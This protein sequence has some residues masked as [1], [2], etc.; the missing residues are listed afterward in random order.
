MAERI[1]I[2]EVTLDN[3]S[4]PVEEREIEVKPDSDDTTAKFLY[5]VQREMENGLYFYT[6]KGKWRHGIPR[7]RRE[8][9]DIKVQYPNPDEMREVLKSL[10]GEGKHVV[11]YKKDDEILGFNLVEAKKK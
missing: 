4:T 11:V 1:R 5:G 3:G 8:L 2:K 10:K 6:R 9:R 7:P